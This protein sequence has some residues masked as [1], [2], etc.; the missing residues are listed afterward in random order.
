MRTFLASLLL[1][2]HLEFEGS[3]QC[4]HLGLWSGIWQE[5]V[6]NSCR[7]TLCLF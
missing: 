2:R 7:V 5:W 4:E 1:K 6:S 3:V